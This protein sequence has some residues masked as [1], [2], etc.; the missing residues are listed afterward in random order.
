MLCNQLSWYVNCYKPWNVT[1]ECN[2]ECKDVCVGRT[3]LKKRIQS[4]LNYPH[5]IQCTVVCLGGIISIF[6]T[7]HNIYIL[8][9]DKSCQTERKNKERKER[10]KEFKETDRGLR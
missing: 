9:W 1:K 10:V 3:N 8:V 7:K 2:R 6:I 4:T 5:H